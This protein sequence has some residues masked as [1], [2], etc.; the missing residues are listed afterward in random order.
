MVGRCVAAGEDAANEWRS[1]KVSQLKRE[2]SG[3]ERA[4]VVPIFA[5]KF[6]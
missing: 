5:K 4:H 1:N 6:C 3:A 2:N